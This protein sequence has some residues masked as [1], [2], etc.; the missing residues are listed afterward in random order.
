[1]NLGKEFKRIAGLAALAVV[2]SGCHIYGIDSMNSASAPNHKSPYAGDPYA[3]GGIQ[4]GTGGLVAG[5]KQTM[6][7]PQFSGPKFMQLAGPDAFTSMGGLTLS[8]AKPS[9]TVGDWQPL[10]GRESHGAKEE[11]HGEEGH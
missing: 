5:T 7:T 4:E 10:P 6:E 8:A 2:V 9:D 1:M 11:G 3:W